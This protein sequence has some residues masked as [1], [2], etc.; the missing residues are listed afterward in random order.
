M[1]EMQPADGGLPEARLPQSLGFMLR[2]IHLA[3][4]RQ[5]QQFAAGIDMP[6]NQLGALAAICRNPDISPGDL[7]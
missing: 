6:T 1:D 4:N 2:R 7:A 3:Y 5:F